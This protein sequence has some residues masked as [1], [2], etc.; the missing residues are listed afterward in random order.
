MMYMMFKKDLISSLNAE[1]CGVTIRGKRL[2]V[3]CYAD[4]VLLASTTPSGLQKLIDT[5][6]KYITIH[7]LHF[8]PSD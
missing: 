5:A 1:S 2:N 7:G 6:V 8:N 3:F 4:D